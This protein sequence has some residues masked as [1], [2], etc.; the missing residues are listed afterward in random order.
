MTE[1]VKM[2]NKDG[3]IAHPLPDAV[4]TWEKAG[5]TVVKKPKAKKKTDN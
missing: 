5:W 2:T 1:R 4:E 3:A